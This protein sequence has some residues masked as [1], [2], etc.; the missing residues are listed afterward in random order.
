MGDQAQAR[1]ARLAKR[2]ISPTV[3]AD[4]CPSDDRDNLERLAAALDELDARLRTP[5]APDGVPF[6]RDAA[7]L[8]RMQ[9]LNLVTRVGDLD[10]AFTPAGTRGFA[11]LDARA[12]PMTIKGVSVAVAALADVIRSKDA[13]NPPKDHRMLPVLRQLAEEIQ[14]RKDIE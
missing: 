10:L 8:G 5:D 4:I 13:A 1:R 6:P 2:Q 7:F 11:D 3:D 12:V 14:R 9:L